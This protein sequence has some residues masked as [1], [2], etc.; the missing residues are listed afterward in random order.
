MA[1]ASIFVNK[2][3][4][5]RAEKVEDPI[6]GLPDDPLGVTLVRV[7]PVAERIDGRGRSRDVSLEGEVEM[8]GEVYEIE[9]RPS[10]AGA[11]EESGGRKMV[12]LEA[13]A[14]QKRRVNLE[15]PYVAKREPG[16]DRSG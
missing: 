9:R 4:A 2:V 7:V 15:R 10:R 11:R 13:G 3:H 1:F 8:D 12:R 14:L 16:L 5:L 6:R